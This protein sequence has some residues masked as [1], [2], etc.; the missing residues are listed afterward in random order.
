MLWVLSMAAIFPALSAPRLFYTDLIS[1][2]NSGGEHN[3]GSFV[4]LYGKGFGASRGQ[5][6]VTIGG[7]RAAAYPQWS[8]TKIVVQIGSQAKTGNLQVTTGDG[9]SNPLPFTVR[10]GKI[11]FASAKGSRG[12]GSF[13]S[14]F[15]SLVQCK[16]AL[17]PGDICYAMDGVTQ[18]GAEAYGATLSIT[19][20]GEPDRPI[21][22]VA[23]PN[24]HVRIGDPESNVHIGIR[25]PNTKVSANYWVI[26]GLEIVVPSNAI[27]LQGANGNTGWRLVGNR[28]SCPYGDGAAAC[29]ETS[30][31]SDVQFL[32]NEVTDVGCS[33]AHPCRFAKG[34]A[35]VTS[36]GTSITTP[37]NL[38]PLT[39]GSIIRVNGQERKVLEVSR[40]TATLDRAFEPPVSE[41]SEFELR[42]T[43]PSKLY[44][45][46][47]FST[48][49]NNVEAAWNYLH[50]NHSCRGIQFHSSPTRHVLP[51]A[52]PKV[53]TVAS[54]SLPARRYSVL[55]TYTVQ[56]DTAGP[57]F[58]R[59]TTVS[60]ETTIN[61]PA[62][63][64][65]KVRPPERTEAA[66]TGYS[67][68]LSAGTAAEAQRQNPAAAPVA[69]GTEWVEPSSGIARNGAPPDRNFSYANGL[70]QFNLSVHDNIIQDQVCD[71]LNFAT[72]DPSKGPVRAYNNVIAHV[73]VG[74]DPPPDPANYSCI[75]VAG[76]TNNGAAGKGEVEIFQN[77]LVDCGR[78]GG[79]LAAAV[80]RS[81]S[82]PNLKISLWN[83]I[84]AQ[85]PGEQYLITPDPDWIS[86]SH[87]LWQGAGPL[88]AAGAALK[89]NLYG[90][91]RFAAP[92]RSD[93]RIREGS[94]AQNK[95]VSRNVPGADLDGVGRPQGKTPSV[96]AY[97]PVK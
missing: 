23:Y 72:V 59:E 45:T 87:N 9:D 54:G 43:L 71:G 10:P 11:F 1:G 18:T 7:G 19:H 5:S 61:I 30:G 46:V 25:I 70:N 13:E 89:D 90:D 86:G 4:T 62:G 68:Y 33:D 97:E 77:T 34:R 93:F 40:T 42:Q 91:P 94:P 57:L 84:I 88:P 85:M 95:G 48:D 66:V 26:A 36:L 27:L 67:V 6:S 53:E 79:N 76:I 21:A 81:R 28:M 38:Y 75:Y 82:S 73:G 80:M 8:D 31:A 20:G 96:G 17:H 29:V 92:E 49:S 60:P 22:L 78:R 55:I 50:G 24:A 47:Y 16:N 44:H 2:P 35:R 83:N 65:L 3:N 37:D 12:S 74:P 14:P 58:Y 52:A 64:V 32:G 41:P 39:K 51:P 69:I 63:H 56:S 15:A